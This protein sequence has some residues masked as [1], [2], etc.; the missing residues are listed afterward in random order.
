MNCTAVLTAPFTHIER[1]PRA[2]MPAIRAYAR[3]AREAIQAPLRP[4]EIPFPLKLGILGAALK[5]VLKGMVLVTRTWVKTVLLASPSHGRSRLLRDVISREISQH[6]SSTHRTPGT[7]W[8]G[9]QGHDSRHAV[10]SRS[11]AQAASSERNLDKSGIICLTNHGAILAASLWDCIEWPW[12]H[13]EA[14]YAT[15]LGGRHTSLYPFEGTE[16]CL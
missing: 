15:G 16:K 12:R 3:R 2:Y 8:Y 7:P 9:A 10:H 1:K 6:P 13:G 11:P 5:E 14:S 4:L